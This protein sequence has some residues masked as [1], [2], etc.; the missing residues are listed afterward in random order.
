M[1]ARE[2]LSDKNA[3]KH[4]MRR[5]EKKLQTATLETR[6]I[7]NFA[8]ATNAILFLLCS[9][10]QDNKKSCEAEDQKAQVRIVFVTVLKLL[11]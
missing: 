9:T 5:K 11:L 7:W 2:N 6:K 10:N 3:N 4:K 1:F 8:T